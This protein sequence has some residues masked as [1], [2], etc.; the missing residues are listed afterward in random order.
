M[1]PG[2]GQPLGSTAASRFAAYG[3]DGAAG[4]VWP[5]GF[6]AE[7]ARRQVDAP[8]RRYAQLYALAQQLR[9]EHR[10]A[11]RVR[12]GASSDRVQHGDDATTRTRRQRRYPLAAFL[13]DDQDAATASSSPARWRS[14]C[15]W[16]GVPARVA[17]GLQPGQ[18]RRKRERVRRARHRRALVGRGV[19]PAPTAGSPSTRRRPRRRRS[20]QLDD[21]GPSANGGPTLPPNFGGRLGQSGDRPFAPGDPGAGVAP[22]GAGGGWK[23]PVGAARRRPR[24]RCSA[25][26]C[27]GAGARRSRRSR[28]SSPSCSARCTAPGA[29]PSP[30]VTLARLESA[31]RRLGGGGRLR[32]RAARPRATARA[33]APPTARAAPRAAPRSSARA[34]ACAGALRAW[35]ALPPLPR[36]RRS[37]IVCAGRTLRSR[38][39]QRRTTSS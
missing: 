4:I 30:D 28:P 32:A 36:R 25:A 24:W 11:L 34:S 2:D 27:C 31:A 22:T 23:L 10:D 26:S 38:H 29:T 15:G 3:T 14:C 6:G 19:L 16:A 12:A 5:S 35:W 13:F 8:T 9:R 33:T 39:G 1:R 7:Q 37:R 17:V 21:G 18:L 20:S